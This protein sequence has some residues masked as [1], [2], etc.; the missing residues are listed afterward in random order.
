M[1]LNNKKIVV[2]L[3]FCFLGLV[4]AFS[5]QHGFNSSFY[6]EL[7]TDSGFDSDFGG[8]SG[9]GWD[10]GS[11]SSSSGDSGDYGNGSY[12]SFGSNSNFNIFI[13]LE[14]II[15]SLVIVFPIIALR[16]YKQGKNDYHNQIRLSIFYGFILFF[17][18]C[19]VRVLFF[20]LSS[21]SLREF[22]LGSIVMIS[23]ML[24]FEIFFKMLLK[25]K[26]AIQDAWFFKKAL[27]NPS[28]VKE[29]YDIYVRIQEAWSKNDIEDVRSLLSS[30][31]FNMYSSQIQTM[32]RKKE[33]NAMSDFKFVKGAIRN[34]QSFNGQERYVVILQVLC[35]DYLINDETNKVISGSKKRINDYTYSLTFLRNESVDVEKC[36]NCDANLSSTGQTVKCP[37]CGSVIERKTTNLVLV[38]KKM[39][40]EK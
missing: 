21:I 7:A 37:Y 38:D 4:L 10:G 15:F 29:A 12:G 16:S 34:Y 14:P 11:S 32:I 35:K 8:D 28:I 5:F 9:G 24:F 1:K 30:E 25:F 26:W 2:V 27:N 23:T 36:P 40:R 20:I 6:R 31:M 3:V 13:F 22:L 39:L 18:L 33:R 19:F 17:L